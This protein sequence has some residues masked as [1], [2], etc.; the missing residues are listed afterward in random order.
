M[1]TLFTAVSVEQQ[2][3]VAGGA[4]ARLSSK[5]DYL[6]T[7][8]VTLDYLNVKP[9]KFGNDITLHGFELFSLERIDNNFSVA[10][11]T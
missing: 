8:K 10:A 5:Y 2:E 7:D 11:L 9:T 4:S 3:I 6:N 1:S